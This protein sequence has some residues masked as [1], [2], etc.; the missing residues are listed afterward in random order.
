[1]DRFDSADTHLIFEGIS[2]GIDN[3]FGLEAVFYGMGFLAYLICLSLFIDLFFTSITSP[4]LYST[5]APIRRRRSLQI[6]NNNS[7]NSSSDYFN[8]HLFPRIAV[9]ID[10]AS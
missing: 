1:M 10:E 9:L 2:D 6:T 8:D 7:T 3:K 5:F 4:I